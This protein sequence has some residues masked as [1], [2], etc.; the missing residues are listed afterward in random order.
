MLCVFT[1]ILQNLIAM[2][3]ACDPHQVVPLSQFFFSL[4]TKLRRLG[5]KPV[6]KNPRGFNNI[7]AVVLLGE[8]KFDTMVQIT[9]HMGFLLILAIDINIGKRVKTNGIPSTTNNP[10]SF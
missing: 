4:S 6:T 7:R 9:K 5:S 10:N 2:P 3:D 1:C 8:I